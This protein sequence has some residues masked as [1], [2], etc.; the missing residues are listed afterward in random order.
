ME[1]VK[2]SFKKKIITLHFEDIEADINVDDLTRI[3]YTNLFAEIITIPVLMNRVGLMKAQCENDYDLAKLDTAIYEANT[4]EM[5]RKE[6]LKMV[7]DSKGKQ[8]WKP[9]TK[10]EVEDGVTLDEGVQLRR[11]RIIRMKKEVAFMDSLY[12]A[13]SNK[14]RKLDRISDSM[15]LKP[16][17]FENE[18][19]E[20]KINGILVK[21][22]K[23]LIPG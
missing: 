20:G 16:E 4:A 19:V 8:K 3:D 12:W 13:I 5:V 2:V 11:R 10:D 21:A 1:T 22:H 15:S 6:L 23:K 17:E 18:I 9:G 7:T 14:A